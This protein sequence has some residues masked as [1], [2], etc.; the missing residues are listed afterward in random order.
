MQASGTLSESVVG[1]MSMESWG[2]QNFATCQ[3]GDKRLNARAL[4]IGLAIV[5]GFGQALSMIFKEE[6][7][8]GSVKARKFISDVKSWSFDSLFS[9]SV[10][11]LFGTKL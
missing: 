4:E 5:A 7:Q 3:L 11:W 9:T 2:I 10:F 6:N 1:V 8:Y